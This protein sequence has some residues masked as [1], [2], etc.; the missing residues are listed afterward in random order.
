LNDISGLSSI[1][2]P[3]DASNNVPNDASNNDSD[4]EIEGDLSVD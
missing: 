4:N 2:I 3:N 1:F